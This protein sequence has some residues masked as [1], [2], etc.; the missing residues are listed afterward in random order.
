MTQQRPPD[1]RPS[2]PQDLA[3][4]RFLTE[5]RADAQRDADR[6]QSE[7]DQLL[8]Q[9][10]SKRREQAEH[11]NI[12][13]ACEGGMTVH[14]KANRPAPTITTR[15]NGVGVQEGMQDQAD[16]ETLAQLQKQ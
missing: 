8:E 13:D 4:Q 2:V 12:L 10:D 5:R 3:F 9:V 7:I 15:L 6:L 14:A 1:T 11:L 16:L